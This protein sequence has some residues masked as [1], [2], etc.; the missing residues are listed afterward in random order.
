MHYTFKSSG[1]DSTE[2]L[3]HVLVFAQ[4]FLSLFQT[5]RFPSVEMDYPAAM[6]W[7]SIKATNLG[8]DSSKHKLIE[9][10]KVCSILVLTSIEHKGKSIS[11]ALVAVQGEHGSIGKLER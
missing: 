8:E 11:T 6:I 1:L 2:S 3:D 9:H 7:G 5:E 4:E 10:P